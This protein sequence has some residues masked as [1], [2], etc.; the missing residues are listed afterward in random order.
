MT[1]ESGRVTRAEQEE[2]REATAEMG[3]LCKERRQ[4]RRVPG[5]RR[6]KTE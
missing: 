4:E 2:T 3:G 5:R 6:H 1:E